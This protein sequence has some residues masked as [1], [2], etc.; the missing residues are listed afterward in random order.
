MHGGPIF[1]P[2][3]D[4]EK[5]QR[6]GHHAGV[7]DGIT[8]CGSSLGKRFAEIHSHAESVHNTSSATLS[9]RAK[10]RVEAVLKQCEY[11]VATVQTVTPSSDEV[12]GRFVFL[13]REFEKTEDMYK[14]MCAAL[15]IKSGTYDQEL[16]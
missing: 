7:I 1:T 9:L 8:N 13:M 12:E 14:Q 2:N 16:F 4:E 5:V 11:V 15:Q 10:G 3:D 6:E